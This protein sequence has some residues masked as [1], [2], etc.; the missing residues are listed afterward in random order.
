[1]VHLRAVVDA[2]LSSY[3]SVFNCFRNP[4]QVVDPVTYTT[5]ISEL[6]PDEYLYLSHHL[7]QWRNNDSLGRPLYYADVGPYAPLNRTLVGLPSPT[8]QH[9]SYSFDMNATSGVGGELT[10]L[11]RG[12]SDTCVRDTLVTIHPCPKEGCWPPP[13]APVVARDATVYLWSDPL[14]WN[15]TL[16]SLLNPHN[17]VSETDPT[18]LIVSQ[19]WAEDIPSQGDNVWVPSWKMVSLDVDTPR[20]NYL[21][22][23]SWSMLLGR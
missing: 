7:L 17:S 6:M 16:D 12:C 10:Y 22:A 2:R 18:H 14:T 15:G 1:M 20:L 23:S 19:V 21:V 11:V 13:P 9:G 4:N 3:P 8:D 5:G